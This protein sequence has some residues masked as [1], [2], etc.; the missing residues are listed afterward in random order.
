MTPSPGNE[1]RSHWEAIALT[2]VPSLLPYFDQG[3]PNGDQNS[4]LVPY[5]ILLHDLAWSY[6]HIH[7]TYSCTVLI[8]GGGGGGGSY[9]QPNST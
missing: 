5:P 4:S 1:P 8:S 3:Y 6:T 7:Y 2:T 9:F